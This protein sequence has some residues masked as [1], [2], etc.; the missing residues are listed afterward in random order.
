MVAIQ[1]LLQFSKKNK[2]F[3]IRTIESHWLLCQF[4]AYRSFS[5]TFLIRW[6]DSDTDQQARATENCRLH[7]RFITSLH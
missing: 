7:F 5:D 6:P 1:L 4:N 3:F 2:H